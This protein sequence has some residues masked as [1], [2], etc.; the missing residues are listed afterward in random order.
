VGG[1]ERLEAARRAGQRKKQGSLGNCG[2]AKSNRLGNPGIS[3]RKKTGGQ[4]PLGKK[5]GSSQTKKGKLGV[6]T[7]KGKFDHWS[8][9][10][11]Q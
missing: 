8:L 4:P 7:K 11:K 2:R 1:G 5:T 10:E 3:S 6:R 9:G